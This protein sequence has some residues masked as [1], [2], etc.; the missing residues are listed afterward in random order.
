MDKFKRL[1]SDSVGPSPTEIMIKKIKRPTIK[2]D[3]NCTKNTESKGIPK[4]IGFEP[5][6][7][8]S[9][10]WAKVCWQKIS[11]PFRRFSET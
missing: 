6:T 4:V 7:N 10:S 2:Y 8:T 5:T 11:G 1:R 9:N 3:N